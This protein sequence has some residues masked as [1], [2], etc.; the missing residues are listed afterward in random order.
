MNNKVR[1]NWIAL[2]VCVV[3]IFTSAGLAHGVETDFGRV[4]VT[5]VRF[6]T[7]EGLIMA[8]KVYR[9]IEATAK[10]PLPGILG[11]HGYQNDKETAG[12]LAVELARRGFVVFTPDV[13]GHGDSQGY[14]DWTTMNG[15]ANTYIYLKTLP[16]VDVTN[17]G[18]YGHSMGAMETVTLGALFPDIKALNP[19][20]GPDGS[21]EMKNLLLTQ[22]K[23]E[24]F[25]G[26]RENQLV[27]TN[28]PGNADRMKNMGLTAPV[29]YNTTYTNSA[30]TLRRVDLINRTH[31][32]VTFSA[33]AIAGSI[34]W[35]TQTL[36]AGQTPTI[37]ST[38][39]TF[40]WKEVLMLL[41]LLTTVTS[42]IFIFNLLL[43]T[44]FFAPVASPLPTKHIATGWKWWQPAIINLLIAGITWP[45]LT[46]LS[47]INGYLYKWMPFFKMEMTSGVAVW[48]FG[49]AII[50]VIMFFF[51]YRSNHKKNGITMVDMGVAFDENKPHL[52]W[53]IIGKTALVAG[54]FF[55]WMY[56]LVA[57]SQ[58]AFGIEFRFIWS[59]MRTFPTPIRFAYFWV[60]LIPAFC[61]MFLNGGIFL[62]GEIRQKIYSSPAVTQIIWWLKNVVTGVGGLVL[63]WAV[64]YLPYFAGKGLGFELMGFPQFS[65][66]W[67]L[68]LYIVVPEFFVILYFMTHYY[69][70]TGKIY[71]GSLF[72]AMLAV[73]FSV[74]GT[75]ISK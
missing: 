19:Q 67:P 72:A 47:Q 27:T 3:I 71:L 49:N 34:D 2:L 8:G 70:K 58:W 24:E 20:C 59:F 15:V 9:P 53:N 38:S 65:Q 40:M 14:V 18:V 48:W 1:F 50:F 30:G 55:A 22:A 6:E 61:F 25:Q 12:D 37:P 10:N 23:W 26:F 73:W 5:H 42:S 64:Q 11:L 45:L 28:L 7:A 68:M 56:A 41:A 29:E 35:F 32:G 57:I 60:Y 16:F 63:V 62:F 13:Y 39:Q 4:S 17:L 74:A 69:R 54:I 43:E 46:N 21:P 31:P 51:W 36:K 33:A 52:D 66:M 75:V 44:K